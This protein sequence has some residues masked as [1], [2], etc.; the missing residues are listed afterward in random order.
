MDQFSRLHTFERQC[1]VCTS[2]RTR[3]RSS[4]ALFLSLPRCSISHWAGALPGARLA[5]P[6]SLRG[7]SRWRSAKDGAGY[8]ERIAQGKRD[9]K[10]QQRAEERA[11]DGGGIAPA[12]PGRE[13]R[14]CPEQSAGKVRERAPAKCE[15]ER[16]QSVRESAG[17]V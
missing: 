12:M 14:R 17:K 5:L 2:A 6:S 10:R 4:P 1:F 8:A 9:R 3:F 15:R 16:R 13:C 11:G 7:H